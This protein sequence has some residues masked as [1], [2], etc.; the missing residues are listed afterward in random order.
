MCW[1]KPKI[2]IHPFNDNI[3]FQKN[4]NTVR[5][6]ASRTRIHETECQ[7][8]KI[9]SN[10]KLHILILN[11]IVPFC[12]TIIVTIDGKQPGCKSMHYNT[13]I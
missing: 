2:E 9:N 13:C 10:K 6:H 5:K 12:E 8:G 3:L 7:K 4:L 11:S 1:W